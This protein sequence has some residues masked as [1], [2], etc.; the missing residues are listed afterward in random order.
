MI[1]EVTEHDNTIRR[2]EVHSWKVLGG[3]VLTLYRHESR[4]TGMGS[5]KVP[6][7]RFGGDFSARLIDEDEFNDE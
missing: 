6:V 2:F 5:K 1:V 4:S 3:G 7:A